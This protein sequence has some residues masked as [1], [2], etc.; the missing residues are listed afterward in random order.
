MI[1]VTSGNVSSQ[2]NER[3]IETQCCLHYSYD[4]SFSSICAAENAVT[5]YFRGDMT[6]VVRH[7]KVQY[8]LSVRYGMA[9]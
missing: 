4:T 7:K 1:R 9:V 3:I 2:K 8:S 5:K 6:D